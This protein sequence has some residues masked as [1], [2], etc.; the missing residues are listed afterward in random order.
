MCFAPKG[1]QIDFEG[2]RALNISL[3][4]SEDR[5]PNARYSPGSLNKG[6]HAQSNTRTREQPRQFYRAQRRWIRLAPLEQGSCSDQREVHEDSRYASDRPQDLRRDASLWSDFLS[7]RAELR[8]YSLA[9]NGGRAEKEFGNEESRSE[10]RRHL[11]R[12]SPVRQEIKT[13]KRQRHR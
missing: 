3:R 1:A 12:C 13:E 6:N 4:R 7:G 5:G 9:E 11:G 2:S 8:F 10:C